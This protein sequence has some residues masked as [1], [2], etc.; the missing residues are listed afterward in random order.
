MAAYAVVREGVVENVVEW[1]GESDWN[2]PEGSVAIML[3]PG[4]TTGPG[5][6]YDGDI[7]T[8]PIDLALA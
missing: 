6:A 1:D 8:P 5:W 2:P 3:K 7:Y 4:E